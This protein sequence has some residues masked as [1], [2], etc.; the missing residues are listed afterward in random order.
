MLSR[1]SQPLSK[2]LESWPGEVP[3]H[4]PRPDIAIASASLGP[5]LLPR[6]P[7]QSWSVALRSRPPNRLFGA[8]PGT[9]EG[10]QSRAIR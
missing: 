9:P 1:I 3:E 4:H 2:K 10:N 6:P 8:S 7:P 5:D